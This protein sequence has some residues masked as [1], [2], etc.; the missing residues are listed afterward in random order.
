MDSEKASSLQIGLVPLVFV[1][2]IG[3]LIT[4]I[5]ILY[6]FIK[7]LLTRIFHDFERGTKIKS[8]CIICEGAQFVTLKK[9]PYLI[10][11]LMC[12]LLRPMDIPTGEE[13]HEYYQKDPTGFLGR[14]E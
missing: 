3:C 1:T 12:G 4:I 14:N 5:T 6:G 8:Q 11:C 13:L 9:S 10:R 7:I 2:F